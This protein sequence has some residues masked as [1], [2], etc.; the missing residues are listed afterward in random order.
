MTSQANNIEIEQG[1][2]NNDGIQMTRIKLE[3]QQDNQDSTEGSMDCLVREPTNSGPLVP[4]STREND[5]KII[6][7]LIIILSIIFIFCLITL[8]ELA[9]LTEGFGGKYS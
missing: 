7:F 4:D 9:L 1:I 2:E 3:F 5:T 6:K 8:T